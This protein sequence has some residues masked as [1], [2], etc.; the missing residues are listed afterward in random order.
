MSIPQRALVE[1][2]YHIEKI[3]RTLAGGDAQTL[4]RLRD[5]KAG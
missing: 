4:A 1:S 2:G 3:L 5:A